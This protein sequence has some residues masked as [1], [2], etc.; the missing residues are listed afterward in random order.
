MVKPEDGIE[1]RNPEYMG[2]GDVDSWE[3]WNSFRLM[4]EHHNQL[5]V[6]LDILSS[7]PS[8]SSVARWFGELVRAA[9]INTNSFLTN[10]KGYPCLSKRHQRLVTAFF[11]HSVQ[12]VISGRSIHKL[13]VGTS[14]SNV[15]TQNE[16]E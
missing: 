6:A 12:V 14:E 8:V 10:A 15:E 2:E 1:V 7:L 9:I 13:P 3:L 11:D 4:C 16:G 5:S